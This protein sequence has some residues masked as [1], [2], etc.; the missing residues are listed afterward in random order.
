MRLWLES[1]DIF[2]VG[3]SV[4]A[5]KPTLFV[6]KDQLQVCKQSPS[7]LMRYCV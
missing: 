5:F 4:V 1:L 6:S 7:E 3:M 2:F